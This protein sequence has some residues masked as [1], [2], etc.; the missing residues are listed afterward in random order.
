M[1]FPVLSNTRIYAVAPV[2]IS[3]SPASNTA[4]VEH[5]KSFPHA[6]P[7][8]ICDIAL[9]GP[10]TLQSLRPRPLRWVDPR[11]ICLVVGHVGGCRVW[12]DGVSLRCFPQS[13]GRSFWKAWSSLAALS[14]RLCR[15][16]PDMLSYIPAHSCEEG[17][18]CRQ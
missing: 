6:V 5:L 1:Y 13:D 7:S 3:E 18:C 16:I 17:E 10:C 14:A 15:A 4:M 11:D 2:K 12:I 8:S 9:A